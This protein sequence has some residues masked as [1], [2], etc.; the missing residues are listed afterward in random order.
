MVIRLLQT[1]EPPAGP[2]L[3][4]S[5][6]AAEQTIAA[7]NSSCELISVFY[8]PLARTRLATTVLEHDDDTTATTSSSAAETTRQFLTFL[9]IGFHKMKQRFLLLLAAK[10]S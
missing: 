4:T 1:R 8:P 9:I 7:T 6:V 10:P 3:L 2:G 5:D